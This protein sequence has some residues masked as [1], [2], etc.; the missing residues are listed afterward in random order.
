MMTEKLL[1]QKF[2]ELIEK[3]YIQKLLYYKFIIILLLHHS[4][5]CLISQSCARLRFSLAPQLFQCARKF[6]RLRDLAYSCTTH[7]Q[8]YEQPITE[9]SCFKCS[10]LMTSSSK[11]QHYCLLF[12]FGFNMFNNIHFLLVIHFSLHS[13]RLTPYNYLQRAIKIY[14]MTKILAVMNAV[15]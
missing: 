8:Q 1:H 3:N 10:W 15:L 14:H 13:R 12:F 2:F 11:Q 9:C 6:A 4:R 7:L 5:I